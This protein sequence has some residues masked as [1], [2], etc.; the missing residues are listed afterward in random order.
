MTH[1]SPGGLSSMTTSGVSSSPTPARPFP[2]WLRVLLIILGLALGGMLGSGAMVLWHAHQTRSA[3]QSDPAYAALPVGSTAPDFTLTGL[4]GQPVR[5]SAYR[6]HVVLVN[7]WSSGCP[8]CVAEMPTL[9][10]LLTRYRDAGLVVLGVNQ[11]EPADQ[12]RVFVQQHGLHWVTALDQ[13]GTVSRQW[14][15]YAIPR[16]YLIAPDGRIVQTW[17]GALN[18]TAV[19]RA[20]QALGLTPHDANAS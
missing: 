20:L 5:L 10:S 17:L 1:C 11:L 13:D 8:P 14:R 12:V 19:D 2:L 18:P 16:S 4:D 6:G 7:F 15:V 9:E 3:T